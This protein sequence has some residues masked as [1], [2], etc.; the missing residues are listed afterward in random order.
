MAKRLA[1]FNFLINQSKDQRATV[2]GAG[3]SW[4]IAGFI[5]EKSGR[6]VGLQHSAFTMVFEEE[7]SLAPAEE[8]EGDQNYGYRSQFY[9]LT[10]PK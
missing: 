5:R 6:R 7:S 8:K 2:K 1:A 10:L 9:S 3:K 4:L